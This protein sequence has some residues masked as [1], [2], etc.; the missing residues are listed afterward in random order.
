MTYDE[1]KAAIAA[2]IDNHNTAASAKAKLKKDAVFAK[3]EAMGGTT[4]DTIALLGEGDLVTAGLPVLLTRRVLQVIATPAAAPATSSPA[5]APAAPTALVLQSPADLAAVASDADLIARYD[6]ANP[7]V[8]GAELD[9]RAGGRAFLF[10]VGGKLAAAESEARLAALKGGLPVTDTVEIGGVPVEPMRVGEQEPVRVAENPIFRGHAL[11]SPGDT[12]HETNESYTGLDRSIRV[13]LR[14]AVTTGELRAEPTAARMA[15]RDA[16]AGGE[17]AVARMFPRAAAQKARAPASQWPALEMTAGTQPPLPSPPG[18][19]LRDSGAMRDGGSAFRQGAEAP[20]GLPFSAGSP[21][22]GFALDASTISRLHAT[23]IA[24]GSTRESL[25]SPLR[26]AFAATVETSPTT[27]GAV[28]TA[29]HTL[30][31]LVLADGSI[32]ML[33]ALSGTLTLNHARHEAEVIAAAMGEI[34]YRRMCG[35]LPSQIDDVVFRARVPAPFISGAQAPLM[36]RAVDVM[37]WAHQSYANLVTLCSVIAS[38][39]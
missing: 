29:L 15:I 6:R 26:P 5:A 39:R 34:A 13:L 19:A 8:I 4:A 23:L 1:I 16:R 30:N 27:S 14:F 2:A 32:P 31:G 28:L 12:C 33:Q 21:A 22:K 11:R 24:L 36:T 10:Y 25:L 9:R 7:G 18:D 35:M 37:T 20:R 38:P 17:A 3:I